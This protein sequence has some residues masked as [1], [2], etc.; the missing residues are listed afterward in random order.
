M[1]ALKS[2][3]FQPLKFTGKDTD[4]LFWACSHFNHAPKWDE[5]IYVQRGYNSADE[6]RDGLILNWNK[7]STYE[8]VGFLLGDI[9]FGMGGADTFFRLL[10]RLNFKQL[11]IVSGNHCAGFHQALELTDDD[12]RYYLNSE[13]MVQFLPNY[14]E[15]YINGQAIVFSH[16][17]LASWNG[18]A[19]GS[20]MLHGHTHGNLIKSELGKI[21]YTTRILEVSV[22]NCPSPINFGEVRKIMRDKEAKAFDHHTSA[23]QNPF[24]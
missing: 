11:N 14:F 2:S 15:T 5:P 10:D 17:P 9:M 3:I 21:L 4:F 16:Y 19:K 22:E 13:K 12:A 24:G 1:N 20:Y 8:T 23:S 6:C 7:K 18:Q